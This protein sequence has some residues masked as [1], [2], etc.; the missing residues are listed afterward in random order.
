[1]KVECVECVWIEEGHTIL[2]G[3][4]DSFF[5]KSLKQASSCNRAKKSFASLN[6]PALRYAGGFYGDLTQ[7]T[8]LKSSSHKCSSES[9]PEISATRLA[10]ELNPL[11]MLV[12]ADHGI[13]LLQLQAVLRRS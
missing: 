10:K 12:Q 8:K 7:R 6:N 9:S 13:I 5:L 11:L 4:F 1:M 2:S 3:H